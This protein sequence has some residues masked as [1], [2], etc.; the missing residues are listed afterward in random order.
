MRPMIFAG[1]MLLLS[2]GCDSGGNAASGQLRPPDEANLAKFKQCYP[3]CFAVIVAQQGCVPAGACM[4]QAGKGVC[5]DNG[6]RLLFSS[7]A[8]VLQQ[9]TVTKDG[10]TCYINQFSPDAT[11]VKVVDAAGAPLAQIVSPSG[12]K[13]MQITCGNGEIFDVDTSTEACSAANAIE[14]AAAGCSTGTCQ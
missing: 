8:G 7:A 2:D 11:M 12:Q 14:G 13:R 9:R 10:A 3:E 5:Y 4:T 1:L 6:V